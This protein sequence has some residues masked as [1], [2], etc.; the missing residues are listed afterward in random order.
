VTFTA[1][2]ITKLVGMTQLKD[3]Q[4]DLIFINTETGL[5]TQ[6]NNLLSICMTTIDFNKSPLHSFTPTEI[7]YYIKPKQ[8]YVIDQNVTALN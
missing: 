4:Q 8:N 6:K 7:H 5:N 3:I 2:S 1:K